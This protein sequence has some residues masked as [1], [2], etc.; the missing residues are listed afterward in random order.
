METH[1]YCVHYFI[2]IIGIVVVVIVIVEIDWMWCSLHLVLLL[3]IVNGFWLTCCVLW[4]LA[5][6]HHQFLY[7]QWCFSIDDGTF[8]SCKACKT[9]T[10]IIPSLNLINNK[11]KVL[12]TIVIS[13]RKIQ[14]NLDDTKIWRRVE[15]KKRWNNTLDGVAC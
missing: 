14:N 8:D 1:I 10:S 7:L 2:V 4:L 9:P 11:E 15:T 5:S 3:L 13:S 6:N 12:W